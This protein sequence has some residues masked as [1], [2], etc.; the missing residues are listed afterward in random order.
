MEIC[1]TASI[2]SE[3]RFVSGGRH[4]HVHTEGVKHT[5]SCRLQRPTYVK[6]K[7]LS[8]NELVYKKNRNRPDDALAHRERANPAE[9]QLPYPLVTETVV[10]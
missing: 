2:G 4:D 3:R 10:M 6:I 9:P 8:P 1:L 5:R 7:G